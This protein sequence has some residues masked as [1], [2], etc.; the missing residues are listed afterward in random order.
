MSVRGGLL[1][2]AV[3]ALVGACAGAVIPRV[4][5]ADVTRAQSADPAVTRATLERGRSLYLARCSGCHQPFSPASRNVPDWKVEVEEMRTLAG[6]P[7]DEEQLV[8]AYLA[9]FA[10]QP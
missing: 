5:D 2:F 6:L 10:K 3:A 9:A 1:A 4:S 7:P 8:L